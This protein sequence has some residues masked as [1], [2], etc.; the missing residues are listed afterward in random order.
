MAFGLTL[1]APTSRLRRFSI[2]V[3]LLVLAAAVLVLGLAA[4]NVAENLQA[5]GMTAGFDFLWREAG[6]GI[7]FTLIRFT[8]ADTYARAL[9][10]G[11]LNTLLAAG[12]AMAL[13][14]TL[15]LIIG[16]ARLARHA[17]TRLAAASYVSLFRNLPLLLLV[18]FWHGAVVQQLPVVRQAFS[19][20][21]VAFL[22]NR[23]LVLPA[24][25]LAVPV[26]V[27]LAVAVGAAL[28]LALVLRR[29]GAGPLAAALALAAGAAILAM[30][31]WEVP[32]LQGFNFRGGVTLVPELVSLVSALTVYNAAFIAEIVRGGIGAV[33]RGQH[34]AAAS[35]GL[36]R[37]LTM[38]LVVLPQALR[39]IIPP[40]A[41]QYSHLIKGSSLATVIGYP[42]LV[43]VFLGT[44]L[45]QTGR[46]I[47]V[48][49]IT[50][51]IFL[52]LSAVMAGATAWWN[53]RVAIRER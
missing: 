18:L 35:L 25:S 51:T 48:V 9:L 30:L 26:P 29:R 43:S 14:T 50:M 15:G 33:A 21:G 40:L 19:I 5:R 38:R 49:A 53:A 39:A 7:G 20:L 10:V 6:F 36:S 1:S 8:E 4:R 47:E 42:D 45:N 22:S 23:G 28:A 32:R 3:Q 16:I 52:V 34:E 37:G 12:L 46:A 44:T 2:A 24:P 11:V 13:A 17:P 27:L 41:N 31:R